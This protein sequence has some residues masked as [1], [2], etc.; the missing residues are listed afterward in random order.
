VIE[1]PLFGKLGLPEEAVQEMGKILL[2]Q[3]PMQRFGIVEEVTNTM[4]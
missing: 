3:M 2:Q 4:L 1:T